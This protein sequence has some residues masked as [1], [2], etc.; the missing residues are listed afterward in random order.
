MKSPAKSSTVG[1]ALS[2]G[3][4][5]LRAGFAFSPTQNFS[6]YDADEMFHASELTVQIPREIRG[7]NA[8]LTRRSGRNGPTGRGQSSSQKQK[9]AR[10]YQAK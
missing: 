7:P 5:P 10:N 9:S 2:T 4:R 1:D 8:V 6:L 3:N